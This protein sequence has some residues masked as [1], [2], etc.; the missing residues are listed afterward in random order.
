[1]SL[2]MGEKIRILLKRKKMTISQ[3]AAAIGTSN[4]NLSNKLTRDNFSEQELH[5]IAEAFGCRFEGFFIF[6]D[7]EKI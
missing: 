5:K 3:L 6:D 7:N 1:M 4:Q 2:S